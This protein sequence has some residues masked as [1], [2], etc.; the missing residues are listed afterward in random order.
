MTDVKE[1]DWW[2]WQE[3]DESNETIHKE[4]HSVQQEIDMDRINELV[5]A[6][7]DVAKVFQEQSVNNIIS[8]GTN[9]LSPKAAR[10]DKEERPYKLSGYTFK[11]KWEIEPGRVENV[12]VNITLRNDKPYEVFA[13]GN[14]REI[15]PSMAQHIDSTTRLVSLALRSGASVET[16]IK[17]L[18]RIPCEHLYSIPHK[19]ANLL[20]EF[21]KQEEVLNPCPECGSKL[22][23]AEGCMKCSSCS[24]SKCS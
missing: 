20:M 9:S 12:Y 13:Y 24:Y 22:I 19:V 2:E 21:A 15:Q 7:I 14:F 3:Y 18:K 5:N 8:D 11:Q 17:Q 4:A 16:T 1:R 23:F 6:G 10:I